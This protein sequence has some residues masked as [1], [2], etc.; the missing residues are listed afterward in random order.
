MK[1]IP[2]LIFLQF[3]PLL[4][5]S[6]KSDRAYF[7]DA[8]IRMLCV[9]GKFFLDNEQGHTQQEVDNFPCYNKCESCGADWSVLISNLPIDEVRV[10]AF[11]EVY[12][13]NYGDKV[14]AAKMTD[15]I[16]NINSRIFSTVQS[17]KNKAK[18]P[19]T[20]ERLKQIRSKILE[21]QKLEKEEIESKK[22][23]EEK[24]IEQ[25]RIEEEN[26]RLEAERLQKQQEEEKEQRILTEKNAKMNALWIF[27]F[28]GIVLLSILAM[29]GALGFVI[30]KG[31]KGEWILRLFS[32]VV[33]LALIII[34]DVFADLSLSKFIVSCFV[35]VDT[36]IFKSKFMPI[37]ITVAYAAIGYFI[38]KHVK[39]VLEQRNNQSI[40]YFIIIATVLVFF[41]IRLFI[42][43]SQV[44]KSSVLIPNAAFILG[45]GFYAISKINNIHL[46]DDENQQPSS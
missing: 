27:V 39:S 14:L 1:Y 25:Q 42:A 10:D 22:I 11:K 8:K 26:K 24:K 41:F 36:S 12:N 15:F 13:T 31:K 6:Q 5:L 2:T 21:E 7:E 45:F 34:V 20:I 43:S 37:I 23:E 18:I 38:A 35:N 33:A 9:A 44:E 17:P 4:V 40:R 19:S 32:M 3:L 29:L 28:R 30:F 16:V 46:F